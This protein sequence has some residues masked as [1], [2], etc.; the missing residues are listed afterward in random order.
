MTDDQLAIH[1]QKDRYGDFWLTEAIRPSL[2]LQ[3]IPQEGYRL[4][5][6]VDDRHHLRVPVL[7]AAVSLIDERD[8]QRVRMGHLAFVGSHRV[9]GVSALHT[10]L[11]R[12]SRTLHLDHLSV[13]LCAFK[14]VTGLPCMACGTT[15]ALARLYRLDLPGAV[16]MNPLSAAVALA[17][18]PWGLMDLVLLPRGRALSLEISRGLAPFVRV[19]AVALVFANWAYLIVAGR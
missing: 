9:N 11:M 1:L 2:D 16:T 13:T 7:A 15:R 8:S 18:V 14:A 10:E 6:F 12:H 5:T 3:V 19:T 17:L 4:D